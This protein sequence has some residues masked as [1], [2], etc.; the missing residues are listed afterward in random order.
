MNKLTANQLNELKSITDVMVQLGTLTE[1][2][3]VDFLAKAGL[4]KITNSDW[5]DAAG[6]KYSFA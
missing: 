6:T 4:T 1:V 5:S 3:Q 2:E